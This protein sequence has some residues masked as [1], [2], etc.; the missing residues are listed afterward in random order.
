MEKQ[1]QVVGIVLAAHKSHRFSVRKLI[2]LIFY[3]FVD[4]SQRVLYLY[5][6]IG[7]PLY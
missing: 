2:C 6:G 5:V 4:V 1:Q 7:T 3:K